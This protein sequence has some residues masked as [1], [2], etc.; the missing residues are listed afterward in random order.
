MTSRKICLLGA[1]AVGKTSLVRRFVRGI[2]EYSSQERADLLDPVDGRP[3]EYCDGDCAFRTGSDQ[4]D[5]SIEALLAFEPSPGT[6]FFLGYSRLMEDI[7][8]FRFEDIRTRQDG[9]FIKLSYL[10]RM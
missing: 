2:F 4:N 6:V 3:L 7:G 9:L 8:S 10:F 5:F 1:S